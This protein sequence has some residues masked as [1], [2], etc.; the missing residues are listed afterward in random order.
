M[1]CN[2][3]QAHQAEQHKAIGEGVV[4]ELADD[5]RHKVERGL[6]VELAF[7]VL[8]VAK[9]VRQFG[10]AQRAPRAHRDVEQDLETLR[11]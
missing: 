8:A 11:R 3:G 10:N 4:A 7:A 1:D 5:Q 9:L 2:S 6:G